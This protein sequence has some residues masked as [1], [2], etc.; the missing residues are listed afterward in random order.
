MTL[1]K[2]NGCSTPCQLFAPAQ[3]FSQ[4]VLL[5]NVIIHAA[6]YQLS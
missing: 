4:P 5:S 3:A 1:A 2:S 6:S